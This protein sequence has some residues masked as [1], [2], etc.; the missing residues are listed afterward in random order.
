MVLNNPQ[1]HR[2][3]TFSNKVFRKDKEFS[4]YVQRFCDRAIYPSFTIHPSS[5]SRYDMDI[6]ALIRNLDWESLF[7]DQWFTYCPE[8]VRLFYVNL[9]RGSGPDLYSF[10]TTVENL[11]I[12]VT[13]DL[14]A[15]ELGLPH[16]GLK[17]GYDGQFRD[18]NFDY[19]HVENSLVHD[20]GRYFANKLDAG[21]LPDDLRVLHFF[22]TSDPPSQI[23]IKCHPTAHIRSLDPPSCTFLPAYQLCIPGLLPSCQ[24][25]SKPALDPASLSLAQGGEVAALVKALV[26]AA[27]VV[28][29]RELT[30]FSSENFKGKRKIP[31]TTL[32][33]LS[34]RLKLIRDGGGA[35][36]SGIREEDEAVEEPEDTGDI[37]DYDSPPHYPF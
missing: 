6:S 24:L 14:L 37:S 36:S 29:D 9:K 8:A 12:T 26:S 16:N 23:S 17:A 3:V 34:T 5:F 33:S 11:E 30:S 20:I 1:L 31:V 32:T 19:H 22:I 27:E 2:V 35:S 15:S 28:V 7:E 10:K 4:R 25:V 13:A 21:R 18:Y